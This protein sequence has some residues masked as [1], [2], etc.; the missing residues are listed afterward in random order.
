MVGNLFIHFCAAPHQQDHSN[1]KFKEKVQQPGCPPTGVNSVIDSAH[2]RIT[3]S[4]ADAT[5]LIE[6][7]GVRIFPVASRW[8]APIC[9]G[10]VEPGR[11]IHNDWEALA[12]RYHKYN[13]DQLVKCG[14]REALS[15]IFVGDSIMRGVYL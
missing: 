10:A 14:E 9:S 5:T 7:T 8:A 15:L 1:G 13:A 2:L 12:C 6:R 3:V 11:W 4:E